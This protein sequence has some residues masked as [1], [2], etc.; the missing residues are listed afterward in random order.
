MELTLD[1]GRTA[2]VVIDLQQGI[3]AH[4]RA[5]HPAEQ[6]VANARRMAEALRAKG[7]FVVLVHVGPLDGRDMLNPLTDAPARPQVPPPAGFADIDPTL[8]PHASLVIRKRQWGAFHGT[9]LDLQL[10]RRGIDTIVLCGVSTTMGV[11]STARDAFERGYQ[12][13]FVEDAM[14]AQAADEHEFAVRTTFAR[15]GRVRSTEEVLAAL[16]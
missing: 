5:P 14:S 2:L 12:Q 13:V 16:A 1:P 15:I 8:L 9:E 3:L 10:R 7:G 6:V 11:E 4:P